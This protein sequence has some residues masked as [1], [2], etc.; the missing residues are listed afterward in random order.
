MRLGRARGQSSC[1]PIAHRHERVSRH[2]GTKSA[3]DPDDLSPSGA[4]DLHLGPGHVNRSRRA[5]ACWWETV[6][7]STFVEGAVGVGP[8]DIERDRHVP[9]VVQRASDLRPKSKTTDFFGRYLRTATHPEPGE[10]ARRKHQDETQDCPPMPNQ[11]FTQ[12]RRHAR[13]VPVRRALRPLIGYSGRLRCADSA[14]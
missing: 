1:R 10:H 6:W 9:A 5:A 8:R 11:H 2:E 12:R 7:P 13:S 4:S 3:T 14:A